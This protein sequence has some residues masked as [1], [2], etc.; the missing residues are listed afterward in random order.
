[1]GKNPLIIVIPCHRIIGSDGSL[2]GFG[3]GMDIKEYLLK[4]ENPDFPIQLSLDSL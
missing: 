1:L 4:L 3:A 2:T